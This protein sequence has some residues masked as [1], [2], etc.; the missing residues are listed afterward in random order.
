MKSP[1]PGCASRRKDS[2]FN[3]SSVCITVVRKGTLSSHRCVYK[4]IIMFASRTFWAHS[5]F[6]PLPQTDPFWTRQSSHGVAVRQ[7][8][9]DVCRSNLMDV[10][11][12][13]QETAIPYVVKRWSHW[14]VRL[15]NSLRIRILRTRVFRGLKFRIFSDR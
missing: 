8:H 13:F 1:C 14:H 3:G 5:I 11:I 12:V 4:T 15:G 10:C 7:S 9:F 6:C 2:K